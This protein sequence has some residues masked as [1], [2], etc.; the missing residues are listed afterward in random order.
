[1]WLTDRDQIDAARTAQ[2]G[3]TAR[4]PNGRI[5]SGTQVDTGW[6]WHLEDVSLFSKAQSNCA[7]AV[8]PTLNSKDPLRGWPVLPRSARIVD[9]AVR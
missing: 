3:G 5:V 2:A 8:G 7:T 4:I 1:V 9:I 6:N